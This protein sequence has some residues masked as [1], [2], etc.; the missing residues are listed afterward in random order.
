MD[1]RGWSDRLCECRGNIVQRG[2]SVGNSVQGPPCVMTHIA[3][4]ETKDH[5]PLTVFVSRCGPSER[6]GIHPAGC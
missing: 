4:G 1:D 6:I 3:L 5:I 2:H